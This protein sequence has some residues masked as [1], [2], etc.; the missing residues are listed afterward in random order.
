MSLHFLCNIKQKVDTKEFLKKN[1]K[2]KKKVNC[3]LF[4][5]KQVEKVLKTFRQ[6]F[7]ITI[8]VK[9]NLVRSS[10]EHDIFSSPEKTDFSAT[11]L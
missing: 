10:L 3:H 11:L 7:E 2:E 1:M 5:L 8:S 6:A 9:T 4:Y